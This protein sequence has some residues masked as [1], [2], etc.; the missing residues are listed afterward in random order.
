M[1]KNKK[2]CKSQISWEQQ[3]KVIFN[4]CN[5]WNFFK[6]KKMLDVNHSVDILK[7]NENEGG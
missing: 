2:N 1:F 7:W 3:Q 6:K 5:T 4:L